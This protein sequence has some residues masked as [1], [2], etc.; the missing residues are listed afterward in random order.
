MPCN[1]YRRYFVAGLIMRWPQAGN[2]NGLT[3][4]AHLAVIANE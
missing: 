3:H 2:V 4:P 1:E